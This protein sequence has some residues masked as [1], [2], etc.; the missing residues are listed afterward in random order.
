MLQPR[1]Y[2]GKIV[3]LLLLGKVVGAC[4]RMG[5]AAVSMVRFFAS[6]LLCWFGVGLAAGQIVPAPRE[7]SFDGSLLPLSADVGIAVGAKSLQPVAEVLREDL[8]RLTGLPFAFKE[9]G[10]IHLA[11]D[12]SLPEEAYS[13]VVGEKE[14]VLTAAGDEGFH[15]AFS[16]FYQLLRPAGETL[17]VLRG[18]VKDEPAMA[19]RAALVDLSRQA[20]SLANVRHVVDLCRFYKTR[21][22]ILHLSDDQGS[23]FA[24]EKFPRLGKK[25]HTFTFRGPVFDGWSR[26][27][28]KELVAY[29]DARGVTLVPEID[30][31]GHSGHLRRAHPQQ[32]DPAGLGVVNVATASVYENLEALFSEVAEV[33][34]S[35]PYLHFGTDEVALRK[36]YNHYQDDP[37]V[38][39]RKVTNA[40]ELFTAFQEEMADMI[41]RLGR[42]PLA[43]EGHRPRK[44]TRALEQIV[45]MN[46]GHGTYPLEAM[47]KD[48]YK[49]VNASFAPLYVMEGG[50]VD[51]TPK[52]VF[53]WNL[54]KTGNYL[55]LPRRVETVTFSQTDENH[56]ALVGG[57]ICAWENPGWYEFHGFRQKMAAFAERTWSPKSGRSWEQHREF[58]DAVDPFLGVFIPDLARHTPAWDL[59]EKGG[60][61]L[62]YEPFEGVDYQPKTVGMKEGTSW[63]RVKG[64]AKFIVQDRSLQY[65]D[66]NG[67]ELQTTGGT[68]V[69][70][71]GKGTTVLGRDLGKSWSLL[72]GGNRFV[73]FLIRRKGKEKAGG[74][75]RAGMKR[76]DGSFGWEN[77]DALRMIRAGLISDATPDDT[78]Y[79]VVINQRDDY[80]ARV[81]VNPNLTDPGEPQLLS[82]RQLPTDMSQLLFTVQG[83][84]AAVFS[85]DE[86]RLGESFWAVAPTV[87]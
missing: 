3:G 6:L 38:K 72:K 59:G 27:G 39:T 81:W 63:S 77:A 35:S 70:N 24:S 69:V 23:A 50:G 48:G 61:A 9:D 83:K 51:A 67:K 82:L 7:A 53:E 40:G 85:F 55:S 16:S 73:S 37:W 34:K 29:A 45:W 18:T 46:W 13:L 11:K 15:R 60:S 71:G 44:K 12:A 68:L 87:N 52:D 78:T 1:A 28:L 54:G 31:P 10:A 19:F 26:E 43:W 2:R 32:F 41:V 62:V 17:A 20:H 8:H 5:S 56:A 22:L 47:L 42:V 30:I 33:F 75:W 4:E 58:R 25:E 49:V 84:E 65:E 64:E 36:V 80:V 76:V 21:Y 66:K 86:F 74:F 79:F 57:C 14:V